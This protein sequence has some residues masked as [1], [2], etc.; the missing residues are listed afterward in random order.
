MGK[1]LKRKI[2]YMGDRFSKWDYTIMRKFICS[3]NK[4]D[5]FKIEMLAYRFNYQQI[6]QT[7]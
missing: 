6:I 4:L 7:I 5:D 3:K 2:S 1:G